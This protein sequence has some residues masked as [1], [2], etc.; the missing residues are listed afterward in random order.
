MVRE[1]KVPQYIVPD[2]SGFK[3]R[4]HAHAHSAGLCTCGALRLPCLAVCCPLALA[5]PAL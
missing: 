4:V 5:A 3:V 2:L 1:H